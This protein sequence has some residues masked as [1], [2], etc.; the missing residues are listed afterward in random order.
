MIRHG[1]YAV[2]KFFCRAWLLLY[3]RLEL[4]GTSN[5]P[6]DRPFIVAA[7]HCSNLDPIIVGVACPERLRYMAKSELFDVPILRHIIRALGAV[8]V[9][10]S[11]QQG[12]AAVL[13]LIL[14][15]LN[16]DENVLLFPEGKRSPDGRLQ[17][18]QGGVALLAL[19]TESPIVPVYVGGSY[20]ALASQASFP[21]P[22]RLTV[23]FGPAI[24]V[25][26]LDPE[27]PERER[28]KALMSQLESELR[29]MEE[30]YLRLA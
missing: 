29:K 24:R 27:L 21:R 20:E 14:S 7:N 1:F 9:P 11:N 18:L 30:A 3:H 28:R 23:H 25:V 15:R 19:K 16:S 22:T 4:K 12:A 10:R 6:D 26:D 17:P 13:K 2:I 5:I 8:P